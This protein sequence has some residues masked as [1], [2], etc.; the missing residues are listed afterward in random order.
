MGYQRAVR[1]SLDK[2]ERRPVDDDET[3]SR[4][5]G[6][7]PAAHRMEQ[8]HDEGLEWDVNEWSGVLYTARIRNAARSRL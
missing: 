6:R 7:R 5:R 8:A 2:R 4:R 1:R 3:E